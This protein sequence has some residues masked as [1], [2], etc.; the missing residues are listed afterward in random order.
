MKSKTV[1]LSC[2]LLGLAW[3]TP[4][5]AV[6]TVY[7]LDPDRSTLRFEA[8]S[9]THGF[10]GAAHE[11]KGQ[12][13]FDAAEDRLAGKADV[14]LPVLGISTGIPARDHAMQ[15]MFDVQRYPD[16][17][18]AAERVSLSGAAGGGPSGQSKR[19]E[20]QGVVKAHGVEKAVSFEAEVW[21]RP[22]SVEV[23]AEVPLE[24]VWFDLSPPVI[25]GFI[26]VQSS[27]KVKSDTF[28]KV[29]I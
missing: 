7:V 12:L 28:W 15:H 14:S 8:S 4:V 23:K 3:T 11:L 16:I 27:V 18:F 13:V 1:I 26:R 22:D 5:L 20:V 10:S 29:K 2:S 17:V 19:Y 6:P 24:T 9:T 21:F 25:L